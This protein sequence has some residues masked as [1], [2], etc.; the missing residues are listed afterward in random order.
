MAAPGTDGIY[1]IG[2][3]LK[4]S[5][6]FVYASTATHPLNPLLLRREWDLQSLEP[7]LPLLFLR[8]GGRGD[9]FCGAK[10]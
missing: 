10:A 7:A 4:S 5:G 9:E 3:K 8:E 6:I 2:V 1:C